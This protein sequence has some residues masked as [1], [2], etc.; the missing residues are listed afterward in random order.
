MYG[1][2]FGGN[3]QGHGHHGHG[4]HGHHNNHHN[5][6]QG[7]IN[8]N[9][10]G[11]QTGWTPVQGAHYKLVSGLSSKMVLDVSQ[12]QHDYNHLIL[13]EWHNSSNQILPINRCKQVWH[14]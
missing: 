8:Q 12:N 4:H 10:W 11:Q 1:G 9:Q 13:Y 7:F 14:L 5:S 3:M 2:N 6:N